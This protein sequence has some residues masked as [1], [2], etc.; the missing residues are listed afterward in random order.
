[1][2]TSS[3]DAFSADTVVR[4]F[5]ADGSELAFNDDADATTN[6]S[7]AQ[8]AV[9]KGRT[10]LIGVNGSGAGAR[11][12]DPI[13]GT[14]AAGG[15]T[16]RY[17]LSVEGGWARRSDGVVTVGGDATGEAIEV[18]ERSGRVR[19]RR[20]GALLTFDS[21]G[22]RRVDVLGGDGDDRVTIGASRGVY[23]DGGAGNDALV[24][25]AGSDTLSAGAGK[26]TLSGGDG[27]DRLNGSGGRD[28]LRGDGGDDRLYGNNGSDTLEGG[29]GTDRLFAGD[30]DDALVGGPGNDKLYGFGGSDQ[31]AGNRGTDLFDGGDGD[32]SAEDAED[33][34]TRVAVEVL[35]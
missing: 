22:T 5:D 11:A 10:Y 9:T 31:L 29:N 21:A 15:S 6:D 17:R 19:V 26:N 34:E 16:G 3:I 25:G 20:D 4:V 7:R 33:G 12:Y 24:G 27:P 13:A 18:T 8:V 14:G 30:G 28:L 1:V 35:G 2:R 32:D 23:V